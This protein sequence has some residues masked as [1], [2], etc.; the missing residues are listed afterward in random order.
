MSDPAYLYH[1]G[2]GKS[3][4]ARVQFRHVEG[5]NDCVKARKLAAGRKEGRR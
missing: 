1:I 2:G 5:D 4:H 3:T